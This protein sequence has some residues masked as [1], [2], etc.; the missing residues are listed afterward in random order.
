MNFLR[1]IS[2]PKWTLK[3]RLNSGTFGCMDV[4]PLY[5]FSIASNRSKFVR[6]H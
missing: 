3:F 2:W 6:S 5:S 4:F 1:L